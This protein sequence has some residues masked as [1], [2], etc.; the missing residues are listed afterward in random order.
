M[1]LIQRC[2]A[3]NGVKWEADFRGIEEDALRAEVL[4][5]P[6]CDLEGDTTAWHN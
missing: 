3:Q 2:S 6:E 4:S 1:T 5:H